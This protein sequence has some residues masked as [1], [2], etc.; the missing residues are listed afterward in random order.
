MGPDQPKQNRRAP[1]K[2]LQV[3][4]M[5]GVGPAAALP[6]ALLGILAWE[7][8]QRLGLL[9]ISG[10]QKLLTD[11]GLLWMGL[12]L[13]LVLWSLLSVRR[14]GD[15]GRRLC[16]TGAYRYMRHPQYAA[17]VWCLAPGLA[18][19]LNS[20]VMLAWAALLLPLWMSLAKREEA[21]LEVS[22]GQDYRDYAATTGGFWPRQSQAK[23]K[24]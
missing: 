24:D 12:G 11:L 10:H 19:A 4:Y 14:L 2:L 5:V 23:A 15:L 6:S 21:I 9:I 8:D 18:L 3:G 1:D 17:F 16:T 22:F 7:L 20:Y 13:G